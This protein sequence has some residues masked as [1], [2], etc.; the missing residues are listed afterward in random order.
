MELFGKS[1][2]IETDFVRWEER[3]ESGIQRLFTLILLDRHL[4]EW[5]LAGMA[6][7]K[8]EMKRRIDMMMK[9]LKVLEDLVWE[10]EQ[11]GILGSPMIGELPVEVLEPMQVLAEILE[12]ACEVLW[13]GTDSDL[14]ENSQLM[15]DLKKLST[16]ET[17]I[18]KLPA[19][20]VDEPDAWYPVV[21]NE[22]MLSGGWCPSEIQRLLTKKMGCWYLY[23]A[24]TLRRH[25]RLEHNFC[26]PTMCR[27]KIFDEATYT[28]RHCFESCGCLHEGICPSQT[29]QIRSILH[30]G[31][32]PRL[33]LRLEGGNNLETL[34]VL[35]EGPYVAFSHVWSDGLGN[36]KDN[37]L[38]ICQL[39]RLHALCNGLQE[40]SKELELTGFPFRIDTLCVPLQKEERK[41]ALRKLGEVYE[42]AE[43]VLVLDNELLLTQF[44]SSDEEIGIRICESNWMRRLWTLEEGILGRSRLRLQFRGK[45]ITIPTSI[46]H[47]SIEHSGNDDMYRGSPGILTSI[48]EHLVSHLPKREIFRESLANNRN[49]QVNK[50][51]RSLMNI[52]DTLRYR[53]TSKQEDE[54]LCIALILGFDLRPLLSHRQAESR[55]KAF[56]TLLQRVNTKISKAIFFSAERKLSEPGF[57]WAPVSL[58]TLWEDSGNALHPFFRYWASDNDG[59]ITDRDLCCT[60]SCYYLH[61]EDTSHSSG[62]EVLIDADEEINL[63]REWIPQSQEEP[64]HADDQISPK[65][66]LSIERREKAMNLNSKLAIVLNPSY[67]K[68][69]HGVLVMVDR[70]ESSSPSLPDALRFVEYLCRVRKV[71]PTRYLTSHPDSTPDEYLTTVT[72]SYDQHLCIG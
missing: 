54:T 38:P 62:I 27:H 37:S 46:D 64:T 49:L 4:E 10:E 70:R 36:V 14:T 15:E 65:P 11:H 29:Q 58:M 17:P 35:N 6:L 9:C 18:R 40:V 3:H 60:I 48:G 68:D 51:H 2:R 31:N 67:Q 32:I 28:T 71:D 61:L 39:F 56:F 50:R 13:H 72:C 34:S 69:A 41:L 22:N 21:N 63:W 26:S 42:K 19:S 55:M 7:E 59:T 25:V 8:E 33:S 43:V 20:V 12:G 45:A 1:I 5:A 52:V 24:S 66:L 23:Y 57:G 44:T 53:E 30:E 47:R 16:F